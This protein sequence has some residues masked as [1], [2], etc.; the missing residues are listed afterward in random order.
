[1]LRSAMLLIV[2]GL[3]IGG[4]AAWLLSSTAK[5]FLFRMDVNDPRAFAAALGILA[6]AA[7]VATIVPARRAAS[8]DPAIA[9][10]AE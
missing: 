5:A 2:A 7:L 4:A 10:R 6:A 9:L 1:V 3:V 8:V